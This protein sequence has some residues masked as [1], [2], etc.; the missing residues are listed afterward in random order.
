MAGGRRVR[1]GKALSATAGLQDI[2]ED[3]AWPQTKTWF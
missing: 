1:P 2:D 3:A